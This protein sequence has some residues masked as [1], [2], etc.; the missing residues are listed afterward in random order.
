L[1]QSSLP[2]FSARAFQAIIK[3]I[4][5]EPELSRARLDSITSSVLVK[6]LLDKVTKFS[7]LKNFTELFYIKELFK[8]LKF[9]FNIKEFFFNI[10]NSPAF[11]KALLP[12]S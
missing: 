3:K 11:F 12:K 8:V 1:S 2:I 9:L 5:L 7:S 4:R 6:F 10:N